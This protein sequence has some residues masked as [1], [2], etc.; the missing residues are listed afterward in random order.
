MVKAKFLE[1]A[2]KIDEVLLKAG[3]LKNYKFSLEVAEREYVNMEGIAE[4]ME[5]I[6]R[7]VVDMCLNARSAS[8]IIF[9]NSGLPMRM[10]YYFQ[11]NKGR[12]PDFE[13]A[14]KGPRSR[15]II[16]NETGDVFASAAALCEQD[17]VVLSSLYAHLRGDR[18]YRIVKGRSYSYHDDAAP[19]IATPPPM[20]HPPTTQKE[21][22]ELSTDKRWPSAKVLSED[23]DAAYSS[24]VGHLQGK[25]HTLLGRVFEYVKQPRS[26]PPARTAYKQLT[27]EARA[28]RVRAMRIARDMGRPDIADAIDTSSN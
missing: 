2:V 11:N 14:T 12:L 8:W 3:V 13:R 21:V 6:S 17:G 4:H 20:S 23:L 25:T 28:E 9:Q 19:F 22:R 5:E 16:C 7:L 24:V 27:K 26:A 18:R 1:D 15:K 10:G